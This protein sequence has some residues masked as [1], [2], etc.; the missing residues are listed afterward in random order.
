MRRGMVMALVT[1]ESVYAAADEITGRG[2][3]VSLSAI[4]D[5]L[6]GGSPNGVIIHLRAWRAHQAAVLSLADVDLDLVDEPAVE[7]VPLPALPE[8]TAAVEAVGLAVAAAVVRIQAEERRTGEARLHALAGSHAEALAMHDRMHGEA[9]AALK[10]R[11]SD[12]ETDL[13]GAVPAIAEAESLRGRVAELEAESSRLRGDLAVAT[14][15]LAIVRAASAEAGEGRAVAIAAADHA[16]VEAREWKAQLGLRQTEVLN[17]RGEAAAAAVVASTAL[18]A[19]R[20][21]IAT[22][23]ADARTAAAVAAKEASTALESVRRDL[24]E[25]GAAARLAEQRLVDVQAAENRERTARERAEERAAALVER[26]TRAEAE[27]TILR[28]TSAAAAA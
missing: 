12:A 17:V 13:D 22:A 4:R 25:A 28:P 27:L 19:M 21:E 14:G 3:K 7:P 11:L 6:G 20:S 1:K 9:V 24:S 26:A 2:A 23:L 18:E 5:E 10:V 15:D 8:V 16:G